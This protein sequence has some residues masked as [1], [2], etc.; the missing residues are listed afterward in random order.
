MKKAKLFALLPVFTLAACGSGTGSPI[1]EEQAFERAFEIENSNAL[2]NVRCIKGSLTESYSKNGMSESWSCS[3][4][5]N[6]QG[7]FYIKSTETESVSGYSNTGTIEAYRVFNVGGYSEVV[8]LKVSESI[9]GKT[10]SEAY[11][12]VNGYYGYAVQNYYM[13]SEA[14][15]EGPFELAEDFYISPF[16]AE[17]RYSIDGASY[18][19]YSK[20]PGSLTMKIQK[21]SSGGGFGY[22]DDYDYYSDDEYKSYSA[23]ITYDNYLMT[24]GNA[25]YTTNEGL[26]YKTSINVSYPASLQITLPNGWQSALTY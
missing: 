14:L 24:S 11:A 19:F 10:T 9:S 22:N 6:Q 12:Y 18:T 26:T 23:S 17:E 2:L 21:R 13:V 16:T 7:A 4:N 3:L 5:I 15:D 20:G 25:Q 8:Y 1:S